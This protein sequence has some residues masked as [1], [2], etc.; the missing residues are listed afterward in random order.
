MHCTDNGIDLGIFFGALWQSR[1]DAPERNDA[2]LSA[3]TV[4]RSKALRILDC[5]ELPRSLRNVR[6][7]RNLV[8]PRKSSSRFVFRSLDFDHQPQ[9]LIVQGAT[10]VTRK[11][12]R[13]VANIFLGKQECLFLGNLDSRRDWGHARDYIQVCPA[14][15]SSKQ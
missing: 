5:G 15:S 7:Q 8:Q 6:L 11:I 13:A 3:L 2:V 10:F 4:R 1:R 9:T 12:T 14:L